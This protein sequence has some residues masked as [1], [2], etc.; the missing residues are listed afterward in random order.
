[1]LGLTLRDKY[2]SRVE[3]VSCCDMAVRI[4]GDKNERFAKAAD[5]SKNVSSH[6]DKEYSSFYCI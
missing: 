1:M 3:T 5:P 4:S 6:L 2:W